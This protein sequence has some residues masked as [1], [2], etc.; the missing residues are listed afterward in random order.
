[1]VFGTILLITPFI[2]AF[3]YSSTFKDTIRMLAIIALFHIGISFLTQL[4]HLFTYPVVALSNFVFIGIFAYFLFTKKSLNEEKKL[5]FKK[6]WFIVPII[7]VVILQLLSTRYFFNGQAQTIRGMTQIENSTYVYPYYSDEWV[8]VSLVKYVISS[9]QLPSVNPLDHDKSSPNILFVFPST[10][11]EFFL[12]TG[13]D[14]LTTYYLLNILV[15]I[16]ILISFYSL[17]SQY[18]LNPYI[19]AAAI[20]SVMYITN[21][22]NLPGLWSLL[23]VTLSVAFLPW[24]IISYKKGLKNWALIY[25]LVSL[26]IYPPMLVFVIPILCVGLYESY[27]NKNSKDALNHL[28]KIL[29]L[30]L[31]TFAMVFLVAFFH[32]HLSLIQVL[33]TYFVRPN[34]DPGIPNYFVWYIVPILVLLFSLYGVYVSFKKRY[35]EIL[36]PFLVGASYWSVY[37]YVNKVFIIEYPR[38]VLITSIFLII[39]WGIGLDH[40]IGICKRRDIVFLNNK[41]IYLYIGCIILTINLLIAPSYAND[42]RWKNLGLRIYDG[43][44]HPHIISPASAINRYLQPDDL[45]LFDGLHAINFIAPPWKGLV[46]GVATDNFPIESKASTLSNQI[47]SYSKFMNLSCDQKSDISSEYDIKYVYSAT[48]DCPEFVEIG[49]SAEGLFLYSYIQ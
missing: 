17:L 22:G 40:I 34:L 6:H 10:I 11:S 37:I 19:S 49:K 23:P 45:A 18:S 12:V 1:M 24:I 14:P 8:T 16:F 31:G 33:S 46:I 2:L 38:I 21:S 39:F 28:W 3:I 29:G 13:L 35:L 15:V 43:Q 47:Y 44:N 26:I 32:F 41:N 20:S 27:K 4:T 7:I 36:A 25:S 42:L 48:F 30:G 9:H 5:L